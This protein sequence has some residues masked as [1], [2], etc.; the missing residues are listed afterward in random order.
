MRLTQPIWSA[1]DGAWLT[2]CDGNRYVDFLN[3]YTSLI[4]G[5]AQPGSLWKTPPINGAR[6]TVFGSASEPQMALAKL[7][8][9]RVPSIE[10]LRFHQLR[11]RGDHDDDAG[12]A[13]PS[14]VVTSSSRWTAVI[15]VRTIS[16]K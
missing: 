13:R 8:I 11:H 1:G 3:N 7:L 9:E 5:H 14:P 10:M 4:H 12:G 16:S 6:G 2:D 15:T